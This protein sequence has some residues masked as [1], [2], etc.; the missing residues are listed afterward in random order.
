MIGT[1]TRGFRHFIR[2]VKTLQEVTFLFKYENLSIGS[3]TALYVD[4]SKYKNPYM[5]SSCDYLLIFNDCFDNSKVN[6]VEPMANT[7]IYEKV[8]NLFGKY[9]HVWILPINK[10]NFRDE[11]CYFREI[12][13]MPSNFEKDFSSFCSA[14]KKQMPNVTKFANINSPILKYFYAISSGS[15]NFFFWAANAYFKSRASI[16]QIENILRWN[17]K[18]SQ[19][20]S[21]LKKGTI[22][23]YTTIS[24]IFSVYREMHNLRRE[25]RANDVINMFNTSQKKLLKSVS[26]N[27]RDYDTLSKFGKLSSKKKNNFIR[28]MST[29]EDASEI[30]RQMSF[31]ADIHFEWNKKSF[32]DYYNNL[33][34]F[35]CEIVYEKGDIVLLKVK[36]YEAVKRLAKATNWCISKDKKYWN[37]YVEAN[38]YATQYVIFDFSK[39]EDDNLSIVG[40]TSVHDKGITY[41]HDFQNRNIMGSKPSNRDLEIKSFISRRTKCNNIYGVLDRYGIKLSD[42]VSH[43]PSHY[44]WN[45]ESMFQYLV[46]CVSPDDYYI[47][48]DADGKVVFIIESENAKYFFGGS[49]VNNINEYFNTGDQYI[50]F[51]DF[52]KSDNDSERLLF[53]IVHHNFSTHESYCDRLYNF[54]CE[55][56]QQTFDR[57]IKELGLPYDIICRTDNVV[58]RFYTAFS[59]YELST[60]KELLKDS[61]VRESIKTM[62]KSGL[63][64]EVLLN[65]TFDHLSADYLKVIYENGFTLYD[66]I[67]EFASSDFGRRLINV[68][69]EYRNSMDV[70]SSEDIELFYNESL[71]NDGYTIY[72]GY[73]LML[74]M[75]IDKENNP[76]SFMNVVGT[77]LERHARTPLYDL[78]MT[79]ICNRLE[80]AS[81]SK[82]LVIFKNIMSYAFSYNDDYVIN[83]LISKNLSGKPY[84][85]FRS[86]MDK[87][88]KVKTTEMWVKKDDTTYVL[89][90]ANEESLTISAQ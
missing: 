59:G 57:Q 20:Q 5:M 48:Y 90:K 29:V 63:L 35:N 73:F 53:G 12:I 16:Y 79:R 49:Y 6:S 18:Y 2:M 43:E 47:I 67:G 66:F 19:L 74:M 38:P 28:K 64:R 32:M 89:Q 30:L 60:V 37:E 81:D 86:F 84:M 76:A 1:R 34:D 56:T 21:K 44:K 9:F 13:A 71:H 27:D 65:V 25:K 70:P 41:A 33:E 88:F 45:R 77:I 23:A 46:K 17:D 7:D 52:N 50:V 69:Y 24:D 11:S 68:M 14:N 55:Q 31:L 15:K 26:L 62:S 58:D 61:K 87:G 82:T 51:A 75:F 85:L 42:V 8:K 54:L 10:R 40:F 78:V 4:G 36:D 39:K 80:C 83:A 72:I 22:T 3:G